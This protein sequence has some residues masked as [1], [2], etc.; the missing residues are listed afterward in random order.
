MIAIALTFGSGAT[1]VASFT[2]LGGV[3]TSVMTGNIVLAGLA[4][5]RAVAVA[6]Q[7]HRGLDRRV[8]SSGW[9]AAP[10]SRTAS[11]R[12]APAKPADDEGRASVL[13]AHVNWTL[14]AEL[15]LLAGFTVGWEIT[16]ARP[17]GWA[18]YC[19]L[20]VTAAA[21]GMQA[22]A[23]KEMGLTDVS[24]TFLT[25]TLTAL[26]SSLV[27]P[28]Q[29]TPHGVRRFGVLIGLAVGAGLC[30]LLVA[31]AAAGVP[32]L[33]LA[34]L[35]T[36]LVL[37][38]CRCAD[39]QLRL[40][41]NV[42]GRWQHAGMRPALK[43][44]LLPVWRDR[45]TLQFGVDPRRAVAVAG[46]GQTAAVLSL[47]D[48]SR[49]R[50]SVIAAAQAYGVPPAAADRVLAVLAAA[51]VLDD[52]PARMHACIPEQLRARLA[53][54][55]ATASLAYADGD[56]GARTLARRRAAYV[57]VHGAG[58]TG[59]CVASFLAASGVGHVSCADPEPA[60]PA[61]LAPA[62]LV[63]ADLG[64]PRQAGAA[65][66]IERAAPEV[67][68]GDDGAVPDLVI[69]T[70]LTLPDLTGQLMRDR[71]PHLALRTGEAIGVVGPL[72]RPGE[73]GL[74]ELRGHAQDRGRPAVAEDPGPGHLRPAPA[75]GLRHR[76]RRHDGH[77]GL[78]RRRW[79][80][81]TARRPS[82]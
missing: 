13:P 51:G 33:P 9:P 70:G 7:P 65:R 62:G 79:R 28:G 18:Q 35:V 5:A 17:A 15:I 42:T 76:A 21:M 31:T 14:F 12:P 52:F 43:A 71:V 66:A 48:G 74:P 45:D 67:R 3:F 38:R 46:L 49:D 82:R 61:D 50:P 53:P 44:G 69:L 60:E 4:V 24:T 26:V 58:R 16:G 80:T 29:D 77:P 30:G 73:F 75:A 59:A 25:G 27:S 23:V 41:A 37:A 56:G 39:W 6:G 2:R 20:A 57:Q 68:T 32:A 22:S 72:V 36:T 34:A 19:L 47:L 55:L 63:L 1:D 8:T 40:R 54:E 64:E 81:S 78:R 10:G 11:R